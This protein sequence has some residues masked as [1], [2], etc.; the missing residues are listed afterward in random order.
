MA[1]LDTTSPATNPASSAIEVVQRLHGHR[2]VK[3]P[4]I[5]DGEPDT[6]PV[7]IM[8]SGMEAILVKKLVEEWR[9]KPDRIRARASTSDVDSFISYMIRFSSP[10]SAVF[11]SDNPLKPGLLGILDYHADSSNAD[12]CGHR[13]SHGFPI[14]DSFRAWMTAT[15]SGLMD[16]DKFAFFLQEREHDI[17]NPPLDWSALSTETFERICDLLNIHDDKGTIDDYAAEDED[18]FHIPRSAIWKLRHIRWGGQRQ[19]TSLSRGIEVVLNARATSAYDP[20]TGTRTITYRDEQEETKDQS[21]RKVIVPDA[22]FIHIPVFEQGERHL[23]PVRLAYHATTSG[24]KWSVQLIDA[25]RMIRNAVRA[26]ANT[27]HEVTNLPI[28]YG[29]P[30]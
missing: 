15:T 13:V 12:N 11:V 22:F 29:L 1:E 26:A 17:E 23:M 24:V 4:G 9:N 3:L 27:V 20:K 14:S 6:V 10:A 19:L 18:D 16:Q 28:F 8:P 21:G 5:F 7:M 25:P 30:E 2:I